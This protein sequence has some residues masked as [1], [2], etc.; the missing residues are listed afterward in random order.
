MDFAAIKRGANAEWRAL[1]DSDRVRIYVGTA[2]C[3]RAAGAMEIL[4]IVKEELAARNIDAD[5]FR[6]GCIGMCYNEPIL[7]IQKPGRPR[8]SYGRM[9]PGKVKRLVREYLLGDNPCPELALGTVGEGQVAGIPDF[10]TTPMLRD[11]LRI[12]LRNCG[13]IDPENINHYIAR[14]GYSG[15]EKALAMTPLA[16]LEEVKK[17]GLRGRGGAGFPTGLKWE[18]CRQAPGDTKY[19]ICNA[20]QGDPGAFMNRSL[21]EGD[22]HAIIEGMIIGAYA[23]GAAEGYIYVRAEYPLA[24]QQLE[25]AI[26]KARGYGLLGDNILGSGLAFD[27]KVKQ[28]AGAFVC[29]EETA[30]MASIEGKR[31]MPR[32]RPP[33]PAVSGLWGKPTN[34]NNTETWANIPVILDRGAAWYAGIGSEKSKGTKTFSLTGKINRTGLIEVPLGMPLRQII[35]D[36]GGGIPRGKQLK[37]VQTGGPSGG[38]IPAGMVDLATDYDTLQRAGSIVGSGGMV[39]MDEDT[40]VVDIARYFLSFTQDE[41]CGKCV[42]CRLGTRQM[43]AILEEIVNGR[44]KPEDLELLLGL[45]DTVKAGSLCGLGQTAP[46]PVLTTIRHFRDEYEEHIREHHCRADVCKGLTEPT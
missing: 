15:L 37:A 29:G 11:Q 13:I 45:C 4:D 27:I 44:S 7:D 35:Y 14:G 8:V 9:T 3:G 22:A 2:T 17:S 23:I 38:C 10:F 24:V 36:I 31:G 30:L 42:M 12:I 33:F 16:V 1:Q 32:P 28:G 39:V 18:L 25:H 21:I 40:C 20:D 5:I 46:N 6:V 19:L 34:I 41:S 26:G 43:L